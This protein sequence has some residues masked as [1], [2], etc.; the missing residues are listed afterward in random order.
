[1]SLYIIHHP[2]Q[3]LLMKHACVSAAFTGT[4]KAITKLFARYILFL[5][6][7]RK[8]ISLVNDKNQT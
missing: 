8:Y 6:L 4:L 2:I 1:M 3:F 7:M 5:K